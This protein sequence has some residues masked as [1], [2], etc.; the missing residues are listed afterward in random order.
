MRKIAL[1]IL[2]LV[3]FALPV[4]S[5]EGQPVIGITKVQL[6]DAGCAFFSRDLPDSSGPVFISS[7]EE[8]WMKINGKEITLKEDTALRNNHSSTYKAG[9]ITV[10]LKLNKGSTLDE[11]QASATITVKQGRRRASLKV[12]GR[13][14]C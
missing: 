1:S 12:K 14:G 3:L 2:V 11:G 5:G 4:H 9:N 7:F 10:I 8:A 6:D 13:C